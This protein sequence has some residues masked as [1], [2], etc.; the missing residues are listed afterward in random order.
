MFFFSQFPSLYLFSSLSCDIKCIWHFLGIIHV[1]FRLCL[2]FLGFSMAVFFSTYC[3]FW[4]FLG[5]SMS[6]PPPLLSYA[7]IFSIYQ[8]LSFIHTVSPT[9]III[10]NRSLKIINLCSLFPP[11]EM[12]LP[13][14]QWYLPRPAGA[15]GS[16]PGIFP[17]GGG[18]VPLYPGKILGSEVRYSNY[19]YPTYQV[20]GAHFVRTE[21]VPV[22]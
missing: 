11:Y 1:H 13:A 16:Y 4:W 19:W 6:S 15:P 10:I 7:R 2:F 9:L 12:Y 5:F 17:P 21:A 22:Q 20:P 3:I 14:V 18:K 8:F